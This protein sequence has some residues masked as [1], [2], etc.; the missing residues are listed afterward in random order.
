MR[1]SY[2]RLVAILAAR[3]RSIAAA[4]DALADALAAALRTWPVDGVPERPEAWL[5]TAARRRLGQ[6]ARHGRVRAEAAATLDLMGE[7]S[8]DPDPATIP[9]ERLRLMLVCAHPAIDPAVQAPLMLQTVLG[10]DAQRIAGAFL[11][12]PAAMAQRLVRAKAKIRDAR[13]PF[14][15][16]DRSALPARLDAVLGAVY[17]AFGTG[18]EDALGSDPALKGLT[19]EAIWLGRLVVALAPDSPEAKGLLALM[20]GSEARRAARRDAQGRFV[21]LGEQDA[22]L[23]DLEAVGEAEG[24]LAAA[25]QARRLG[26]FQVEACIQSVHLERRRTGRTDW[27]ALAAF[28]ELLVRLAPTLGN[29]VA[30]AAALAEAAGPAAG[31]AVLDEIGP[32]A[33]AYQPF[34]ATRAHLLAVAGERA[35]AVEAWNRAAGMSED[36]AV[37][38]FLLDKA[39]SMREA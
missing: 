19:E 13:I 10:L 8:L 27:R 14:E 35:A 15:V 20:L 24:L 31:L 34:W 38:A 11:T 4:E 2:G 3:S 36:P 18:W 9:D 7:A 1:L 17:A 6:E 37:R 39:R 21:P 33:R 25:A 23:W 12:S 28:Y 30:R 5:V 16:P 32:E 29:R 26:R 22:T